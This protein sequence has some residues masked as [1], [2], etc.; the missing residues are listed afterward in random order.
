ML[1]NKFQ[2]SPVEKVKFDD[3]K[4]DISRVAMIIPVTPDINFVHINNW[5]K[6]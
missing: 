2:H 3:E 1:I 6:I 4:E 5:K